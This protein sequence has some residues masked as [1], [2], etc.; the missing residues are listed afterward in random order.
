MENIEKSDVYF[1]IEETKTQPFYART[2][3]KKIIE[4]L[5]E[6]ERGNEISIIENEQNK[7]GQGPRQ[8]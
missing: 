6:Y 3:I 7:F 5:K 2:S 4:L 1:M 8:I